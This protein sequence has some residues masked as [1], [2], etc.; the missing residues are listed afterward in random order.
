MAY[1]TIV[2]NNPVVTTANCLTQGSGPLTETWGSSFGYSNSE[3]CSYDL[4]VYPGT[5]VF[6]IQS[7]FE[8]EFGVDV[9]KYTDEFGD[10]FL[11]N[12][13]ALRP[14]KNDTMKHYEFNFTSDG[15]I[16]GR[17]FSFEFMTLSKLTFTT[18][19]TKSF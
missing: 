15:S 5:E 13:I 8:V 10:Y 4:Y 17:G 16:V 6:V 3:T 9:I 7:D 19:T 2:K 1:I 12:N 11:R 14:Y 18:V